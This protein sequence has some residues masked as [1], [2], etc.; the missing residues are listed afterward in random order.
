MSVF[1]QQTSLAALMI[2][3]VA[4]CGG[5][6]VLPPDVKINPSPKE[7]YE[8][9]PILEAPPPFSRVTGNADFAIRNKSCMPLEDRIAGIKPQSWFIRAGA[10]R[11]ICFSR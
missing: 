1:G 8:I 10:T 7:R 11:G 6:R 3:S 4:A 9:T 5:P 2:L